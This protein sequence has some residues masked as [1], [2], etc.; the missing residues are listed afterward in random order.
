[1][2]WT[3]VRTIGQSVETQGQFKHLRF[4][5]EDRT[6]RDEFGGFPA[7]WAGK[8]TSQ[9]E[10]RRSSSRTSVWDK[11]QKTWVNKRL[12]VAAST[13]YGLPTAS[14]DE[15]ILGLIQLTLCRLGS[16][17]ASSCSC[18]PNCFACLVGVE[19]A[20]TTR[21]WK[22]RSSDGSALRSTMIM[23]GGTNGSRLGWTSIFTCSTASLFPAAEEGR[24][25][26]S[27]GDDVRRGRSPGT[28]PSSRAFRTAISE[29]SIWASSAS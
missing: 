14:D 8:P 13:E 11:R 1:M 15:V 19:K 16:R 21:D 4:R 29:S 22:S 27:T 2:D 3:K 9:G 28:R 10:E 24:G 20:E 18:P 23:L 25:K 12:T 6:R 26:R 7:G 17:T 5:D